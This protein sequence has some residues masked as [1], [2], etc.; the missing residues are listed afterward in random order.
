MTVTPG[1]SHGR[2]S[3]AAEHERLSCL[4]SSYGDYGGRPSWPEYAETLTNDRGTS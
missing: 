3:S 2:T 4:L 1:E